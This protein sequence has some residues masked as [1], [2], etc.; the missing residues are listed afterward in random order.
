MVRSEGGDGVCQMDVCE[1][2]LGYLISSV[3]LGTKMTI[4]RHEPI[5]SDDGQYD[6]R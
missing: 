6:G 1:E 5:P 2:C 4:F 3:D